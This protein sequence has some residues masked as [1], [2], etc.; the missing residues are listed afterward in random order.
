MEKK[1]GK[2]KQLKEFL[3]D[4]RNKAI[5]KLGFWVIFLL[6][7]I[8]YV[9]VM[10]SRN[11]HYIENK[12]DVPTI[13]LPLTITEAVKK[14]EASNY[15]FSFEYDVNNNKSIV[16]GKKYNDKWQFSYNENNYYYD[17]KLYLI[18][19]QGRVEVE[20][21][22]FNYILMLD[23]NKIYN[24]LLKS[25][26]DYKKESSDGTITISS[27]LKLKDFEFNNNEFNDDIIIETNELNNDLI[28]ISIDL[29]NYFKINNSEILSFKVN[30]K[31]DKFNM[32]ENFN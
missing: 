12:P 23:S 18:N 28:N 14:L 19:E 26:Y 29:T 10:N 6:F 4:K 8:I 5:V 16:N 1:E 32:V 17:G 30:L 31:Y 15:E 3:S 22:N 13:T 20:N 25:E 7:V 9:R 24:Y 2:I 11:N 27:K 21:S